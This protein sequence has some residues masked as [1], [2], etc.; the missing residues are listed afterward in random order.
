LGTLEILEKSNHIK[1][2]KQKDIQNLMRFFTIPE[3]TSFYEDIFKIN[4][5]ESIDD[6]AFN[7]EGACIYNDETSY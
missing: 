7:A 4:E 6:S 2:Q 1:P 5:F 3:T